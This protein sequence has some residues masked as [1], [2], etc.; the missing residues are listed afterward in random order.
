V[1][2][3]LAGIVEF[4]GSTVGIVV[5]S[6]PIWG[7]AVVRMWQA[8][9]RR[10]A[11]RDFAEARHLQFVGTTP[12]DAR[13]PYTRIGLVRWAVLLSNVVE[14][15]WDGLP[16]YLFDMPR[17]RRRAPWTTAL[18]TVGG[19][20]RS[21]PAA[22]AVTSAGPAALIE[23]DLDV[24]CVSPRRLL[25]ASELAGFLT[26]ATALAKAMEHDARAAGPADMTAATSQRDRP[27]FGGLH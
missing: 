10:R 22:A 21:G 6:S 2:N 13:P 23:T 26:F 4:A 17:G 9:Q 11:F 7:L 25:E 16:V 5:L 8:L 3:T 19:T 27:L 1:D 14:G 20:L 12:S 15:N 24:L 18:V